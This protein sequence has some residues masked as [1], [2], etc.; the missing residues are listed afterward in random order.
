MISSNNQPRPEDRPEAEAARLASGG[1]LVEALGKAERLMAHATELLPAHG[2]SV[3]CLLKLGRRKDAVSA[4]ASYCA[5]PNHSAPAA[6]SLAYAA[7]ALGL[8]E[9]SNRLYRL[10]TTLAPH[11]PLLWYNLATSERSFGRLEAAEGACNR[12]IALDPGQ[13]PSYLL[14]AEL[15]DQTP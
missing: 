5:L 10:A 6:D 9:D 1:R 7:R 12:S 3:L 11:D 14:R 2:L 8:H 13:F 15:R 4:V